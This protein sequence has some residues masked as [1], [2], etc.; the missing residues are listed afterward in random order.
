[1][2]S[3]APEDGGSDGESDGGSSPP[4]AAIGGGAGAAV[5]IIGIA[6][7]MYMK[8]KRPGSDGPQVVGRKERVSKFDEEGAYYGDGE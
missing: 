4:I 1:M 2:S 3:P 5:L 7:F 8:G 6:A